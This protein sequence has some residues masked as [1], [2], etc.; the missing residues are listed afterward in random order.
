MK[1]VLLLATG[2]TIACQQTREGLAPVLDGAALL[3]LLPALGTICTATVCDLMQVDSTDLTTADRV[4]IAR[5]VWDNRTAY[6][7]FVIAHGTDTLAA[8]AAL[9]DH[10][11]PGIDRP[12]VLTGS[13][14][15]MGAPGSDAPRNLLDAFR[16]AAAG[17]AG[18][19]AVL[20]GAILPGRHVY[21]RHSTAIDAF[22]AVG[23]PPAGAV[24]ADGTI[25]W[26]APPRPAG[27]PAFR[28]AAA[29]SVPVI[30]LT[31]DLDPAFFDRLHGCPH[32]ILETYGAGGLPARLVS[33]VGALIASGTQVYL[34]T[35]CTEGGV[36]LHKYAVGQ[37]AEALGAV[38]LG[39]RTIEDAVAA[40]LCGEL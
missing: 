25:H 16:V 1:N 8:T 4:T 10:M 9:L 31:S 40:I 21:K 22:C 39:T 28:P 34:T 36:D 6:D 17:R 37:R 13:M 30:R 12:V 14:L 20:C 23:A 2:G 26:Q 18:V 38:S 32:L 35:Q 24:C 3:G 7:G 5:A 29:R 15:P 27:K 11:L 19:F 33:A